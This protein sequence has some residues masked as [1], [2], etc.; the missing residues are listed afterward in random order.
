MPRV[1]HPVEEDHSF[2][3]GVRRDKSLRM[4]SALQRQRTLVTVRATAVALMA[5]GVVAH[6]GW[7]LEFVVD[8]GLPT[9]RSGPGE[10]TAAGQPHRELFRTA[11]WVSGVA[12]VLAAP[13]LLR[14]APVHWQSRLT[15]LMVALFGVVEIL[16]GTFTYDCAV[17]TDGTACLP[18]EGPSIGHHVHQVTGVLLSIQ[19]ALGPAPLLLWW[20]NRWR[21]V[22]G[23]L[24][25]IQ[26]VAWLVAMSGFL[27]G[28]VLLAGIATRVQ[29]LSAAVLLGSGTVYVAT[30]G[31][32]T[33]GD[34]EEPSTPS[35]PRP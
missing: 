23:V 8:T 34:V 33:R 35:V 10:L 1:P 17:I 25:V 29:L 19:I 28:D 32:W 20:R 6:L 2:R 31:R 15:V 21:V 30:V 9:P 11:E 22:A 4:P 16:H 13:P 12:F 18:P 5:V 27:G 14:L 26:V 7:V 3:F 24:L